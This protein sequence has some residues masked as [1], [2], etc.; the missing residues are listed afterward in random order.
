MV[1]GQKS[2]GSKK[3]IF[4]DIDGVLTPTAEF[5]PGESPELTPESI[6]VLK[7]FQKKSFITVFVTSRSAYELR[8]KDGFEE[9][10][11]KKGL[12][13]ESLIFASSGLDQLT[14]A[15]E[16]K[17]KN[18][19][20]VIRNGNALIILKPVTKRETFSNMDQFV[21]YKMLLGREIKQQLKFA[22]FK[23]KPAIIPELLGDARIFFE[24]ETNSK[25]ERT[26]AVEEAKKIVEQ[27]REIFKT[28]GKFGSPIDLSVRDIVA[29]ISIE[30]KE[31]GKHFGVLRA[32]K[33]LEVK[34]NEKIT[35]YA[36]GDAE[37]DKQMRIRKDINFIKVKG[38]RDF[39]RKAKEVL[40]KY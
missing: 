3:I 6:K 36:F 9:T 1:R 16:F 14:Y 12:A 15:H 13:K 8:K 32:L 27:Q 30:P 40:A 24:L 37:S 2:A 33:A 38:N 19:K 26:K 22:G 23:I 20:P 29:G 18:G 11:R 35:A 31:M 28:T 21:L 17:L 5:I 34:P 4:L 39:L 25:S 7:S 10:L